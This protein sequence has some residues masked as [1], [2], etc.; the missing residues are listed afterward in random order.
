MSSFLSLNR[1]V[2]RHIDAM[3]EH[4]VVGNKHLPANVRKKIIERTDGIPLF[5]RIGSRRC[6]RRGGERGEADRWCSS[7]G[8]VDGCLPAYTPR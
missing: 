1:L 2:Q 7:I 8:G 6:L 4:R 3:I 5:G